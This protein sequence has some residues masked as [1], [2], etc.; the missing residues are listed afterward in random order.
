MNQYVF[1]I[2]YFWREQDEDIQT[3]MKDGDNQVS[4]LVFQ[5]IVLIYCHSG[6]NLGI[7]NLHTSE[8]SQTPLLIIVVE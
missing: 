5:Q 7:C 6:N 4:Y 1:V 8:N 2:L 3:L